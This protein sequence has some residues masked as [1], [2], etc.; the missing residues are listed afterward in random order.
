MVWKHSPVPHYTALPDRGKTRWFIDVEFGQLQDLS[1]DMNISAC[2]V[3]VHSQLAEGPCHRSRWCIEHQGCFM[4]TPDKDGGSRW[5]WSLSP[6]KNLFPVSHHLSSNSDPWPT[7]VRYTSSSSWFSKESS[8]V[9]IAQSVQMRISDFSK[10][11]PLTRQAFSPQDLFLSITLPV[12]LNMKH[13]QH[14]H[15][16][17]NA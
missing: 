17:V 7:T 11:V 5:S 15:S 3:R 6:S 4:K 8:S 10:R 14:T 12:S 2:S 1:D 13:V 16:M 9:A